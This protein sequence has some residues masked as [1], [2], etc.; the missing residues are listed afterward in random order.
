MQKHL[1]EHVDMKKGQCLECDWVSGKNL[2][3][4]TIEI[5]L[6]CLKKSFKD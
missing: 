5:P 6:T 2:F 1:L 3:V 4:Q